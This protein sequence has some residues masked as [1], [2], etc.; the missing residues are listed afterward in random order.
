MI[1]TKMHFIHEEVQLNSKLNDNIISYAPLNF[2]KD[3]SVICMTDKGKLLE[4][5][6]SQNQFSEIADISD[7]IELS[8]EVCIHISPD[9]SLC[10]VVNKFGRTGVVI[11]LINGNILMSLL[12]D[13]YHYDVTT[14]PITFF[15]VEGKQFLIHG[16][17]WNRLDISDPITGELYTKRT[18]PKF[19]IKNRDDRYLDYFHSSLS[20]SPNSRWIIDNGW[21]WH[22]AGVLYRWDAR[23]WLSENIWESENGLSK[24]E[25]TW[26]DG[27][28]DRPICWISDTQL[29]VWGFGN[30]DE[31]TFEPSLSIFD[32]DTCKEIKRLN[33]IS[34]FLVFDKYLFS[35]V[36]SKIL[37]V[38]GLRGYEKHFERRGIS[39]W[40]VVNG[41]ELLHEAE[42]SPN[43]YHFGSK[44]FVTYLGNGRFMISRL[45]EK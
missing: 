30:D 45:V 38:C 37:D 36:P 4:I 6:L 12:R 24:K 32:I 28:W 17:Q 41:H 8:L 42:I 39:V 15:E 44:A 20:I 26:C 9:E 33:G 27:L 31:I 16:T 14:F 23:K 1:Q 43:L 25:I 11:E 3:T 13:D 40:D 22:P 21:V 10:A 19:D 35:I 29:I 5:S 2:K 7:K 34:G 18:L